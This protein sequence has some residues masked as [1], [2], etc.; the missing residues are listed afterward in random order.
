LQATLPESDLGDTLA[1]NLITEK[2]ARQEETLN[3]LRGRAVLPGLEE[4]ALR[5]LPTDAVSKA[6]TSEELRLAEAQAANI[7]FDAWRGMPVT[8][9]KPRSGCV[10]PPARWLRFESRVS[11]KS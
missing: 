7:Y 3:W 11:L 9:Q 6:K 5:A 1:R 2:I 4:Y 8:F 10:E